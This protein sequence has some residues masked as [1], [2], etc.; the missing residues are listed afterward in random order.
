MEEWEIAEA[1]EE[2]EPDFDPEA[3]HGRRPDGQPRMNA[4]NMNRSPISNPALVNE[5]IGRGRGGGRSEGSRARAEMRR[6][7]VSD[8]VLQGFSQS[9]IATQLSLT[10]STVAQDIGILKRRWREAQLGS[11]EDSV[12]KE[13]ALLDRRLQSMA[14]LALAGSIDHDKQLTQIAVRKAKLLGL[15][16]AANV[17]V[18]LK[19]AEEQSLDAKL[20]WMH[21]NIQAGKGVSTGWGE[22]VDVRDA[23]AATTEESEAETEAEE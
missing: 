10:A 19:T 3:P 8:L 14:P 2:P 7:L 15:D 4:L 5:G 12:A 9:Q 22:G 11:I 17:D 16:K 21:N 6:T 1:E 23:A 20:E 18:T 13:A